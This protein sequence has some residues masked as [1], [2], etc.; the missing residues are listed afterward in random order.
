MTQIEPNPTRSR[1]TENELATPDLANPTGE[2]LRAWVEAILPYWRCITGAGLR[3]TLR[4]IGEQVPLTCTEVPTGTPVLDWTIPPEWRVH[5][6]YIA[7]PDGTRVVDGAASPLHLVQYSTPVY[8]TM[9]LAELRPHLHTLPDHPD[10]IPYRTDY[11]TDGWGFCLRQST[12][13]ELAAD[14][15]EDGELKVVI[16]AELFEGSLTYGEVVLPGRTEDEILISAHACH[17]ALA[18]DN[19]SSL[20]VATAVARQLASGPTLRHTVRFV[21]APGTI[22]GIAWLASNRQRVGRIQHG[23]VLANLGDAGGFTYKQTR[24]GVSTVDRVVPE[25]IWQAGHAVEVRA[26]DPFGYDERQYG[27][28]GFDL[29]VG[30]L[31]RTPHAEYPEYHTSAD[32]MSLM[33]PNALADSVTMLR[34]IIDAL[35]RAPAAVVPEPSSPD[36]YQSLAPYGEPQLGRRGLY[37]FPDGTPHPRDLQTAISWVLSFGDGCHTLE[38]VASRSGVSPNVIHRAAARLFEADLIDRGAVI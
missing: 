30:R 20:A 14:C 5:D 11:Y 34:R 32:D 8:A 15:G 27:S 33:D 21:F 12:L 37:A 35:D 3:E 4:A 29:P 38:Q 18:N 25:T 13:D 36:G 19:A 31:T 24:R 16:D 22:G 17:P 26:F 7:R 28:P 6:A 10:W 1:C 23:L 2:A 9:T